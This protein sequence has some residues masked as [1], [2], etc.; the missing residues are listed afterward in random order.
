[1]YP[2]LN[3]DSL[4][5]RLKNYYEALSYKE[6]KYKKIKAH[7]KSVWKEP[8]VKRFMLTLR[9]NAIYIIGQRKAFYR[10]RTAESSCVRKRTVGILV[11]SKNGDRKIMQSMRIMRRP[12]SRI[13]KWNQLSQFR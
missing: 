4:H 10:Q 7:R 5:V 1:M 11:T 8:I 2:F 9:L 6:K 12:P 13:R 3:W